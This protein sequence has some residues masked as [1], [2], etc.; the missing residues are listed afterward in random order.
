MFNAMPCS[1]RGSL[2]NPELGRRE[3]G[4]CKEG[5][6]TKKKVLSAALAVSMALSMTPAA[7]FAAPGAEGH[8][9]E[10]VLGEW[11]GYGVIKGYDDGSGVGPDNKVARAEFVTM[12]DRVMGY[13]AKAENVYSDV[14]FDWYTDYILKGAAAGVIEGDE[15]GSTM[16]PNDPVF[17]QEACLILARV[18]GLDTE[19]APDA[20]F[21][22][23][24]SVADWAAG[25]VN[26]MRAEGYVNGSDGVFRPADP[27]TRA[28]AVKMLDNIFAGLY[29]ESGEY[30]GDMDGSAVVSADGVDL[31]GQTI[32]GDLVIAEGVGDGHVELDGVTVEGHVIVRGGVN[33]VIVKGASKIGEI[34]V[35]RQSDPV[36][37]AVEGDAEVGTV[38]VAEDTVSLVLEGKVASV[39]V[40]TPAPSSLWPA[41][42][43]PSPSRATPPWSRPSPA[44]RSPRSRPT[45]RAPWSRAR[46]RSSP[47]WPASPPPTSWSPPKEPR[48]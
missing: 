17:R 22:D 14:A 7:A 2:P 29:Q 3:V 28:E 12:L 31:K 44:A 25:A 15:S 26:A 35:D 41:R 4:C 24:A 36:R 13:K 1:E 19:S 16:R 11:M 46:A 45:P 9:A 8:W 40:E 43:S 10:G 42:S 18:L 30:S 38:T 37:V 6:R 33:S 48:S 39:S 20:G 32:E 5:E 27:T 21:D 34:V 47:S 23:Q